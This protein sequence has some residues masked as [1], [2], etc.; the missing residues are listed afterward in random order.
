MAANRHTDG[1]FGG[2]GLPV[3]RPRACNRSRSLLPGSDLL[4]GR[5]LGTATW[6]ALTTRTSAIVW[7]RHAAFLENW[8]LRRGVAA[9][10]LVFWVEAR[11]H[12]SP[13][14]IGATAQEA[15]DYI[16]TPAA[17]ESHVAIFEVSR[18]N[19]KAQARDI[20]CDV[21]YSLR[22]RTKYHYAVRHVTYVLGT[23]GTVIRTKSKWQWTAWSSG[24]TNAPPTAYPPRRIRMPNPSSQ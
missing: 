11:A 23:N 1:G 4:A 5:S 22:L 20:Q 7:L 21:R 16:H 12:R 24:K 13:L 9:F 18:F 8:F 14:R 10:F 15:W 17:W 19:W 2:R 6:L 3:H